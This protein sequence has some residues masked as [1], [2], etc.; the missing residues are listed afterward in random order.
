MAGRIKSKKYPPHLN[1]ANKLDNDYGQPWALS[2]DSAAWA[3]RGLSLPLVE[4]GCDATAQWN[5]PTSAYC[6]CRLA[7]RLIAE[8]LRH[9]MPQLLFPASKPEALSVSELR[10]CPSCATLK[11]KSEIQSAAIVSSISCFRLSNPYITLRRGMLPFL[12][13]RWK[14]TTTELAGGGSL[15]Q[16][17]SGR[18]SW[19]SYSKMVQFA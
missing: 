15:P 9:A 8:G 7:R 11:K 10:K 19:F 1:E 17:V 13:E 2:S 12:L 6:H 14:G 3:G 4:P 5:G 18:G 16:C